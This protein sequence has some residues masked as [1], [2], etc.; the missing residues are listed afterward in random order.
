[1]ASWVRYSPAMNEICP[2][3]RAR[4]DTPRDLGPPGTPTHVAVAPSLL[5]HAHVV[6]RDDDDT[7]DDYAA[8]QQLLDA[9][10]AFARKG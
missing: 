9:A 7:D 10:L 6:I 2:P 4:T 3:R 5:D 1:M 8:K